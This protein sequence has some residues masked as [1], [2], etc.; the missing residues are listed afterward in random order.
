MHPHDYNLDQLMEIR[1]RGLRYLI[2]PRYKYHYVDNDYE[3]FSLDVFLQFATAGAL[4]VDVGAHFGIYSLLAARAGAN[5]VAFEPVPE[6]FEVL[7][8]NIALNQLAVTA[9]QAAAS[10]RDGLRSFNVAW[11]S[12]SASFSTHP[13]AETIARIEVVTRSLDSVLGESR[14]DVLKIDTEGHEIDVIRGAAEVLAANPKVK[15]LVE[16]G[17]DCLGSAGYEPE[18]LLGTLLSLGLRPYMIHEDD[19]ALT[20]IPDSL[21]WKDQM[22]G[23][24]YLNLICVADSPDDGLPEPLLQL[25]TSPQLSRSLSVGT[26]GRK[27]GR[28]PVGRLPRARGLPSLVHRGLVRAVAM[29]RWGRLAHTWDRAW[30]R[31]EA[32]WG[33]RPVRTMLHGTPAVLN[34]GHPYPVWARRWPSYNDP[35]VEAVLAT[36]VMM[37]RPVTVLDIGA[38]VGDTALLL[39]SSAASAIGRLIA[40]EADAEFLRYLRENLESVRF[41]TEVW[42]TYLSRDGGRL[43]G[44][45]RTQPGTGELAGPGQTA[46]RRL[47]DVWAEHGTPRVDVIKTDTDGY[48]GQVLAGARQLITASKPVIVFEWAPTCFDT[49]DNDAHEP[50][51]VLSELGYDR[52]IWFDK[53]GT[54]NHIEVG[55]SATTVEAQAALCRQ[56]KSLPS[57]HY[58][59]IALHAGHDLS[60][61]DVADLKRAF[62]HKVPVQPGLR[63]APSIH[64]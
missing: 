63:R 40:V 61:V 4:V 3:D 60:A 49:T 2:M 48:E 27:G 23:R 37:G 13:N 1:V 56:S 7:Q 54:F 12:D 42:P 24:S 25:T 19:R 6:N 8:R 34:F 43:P 21:E 10:D 15:V 26:D 57:W 41:T 52:F 14:V 51:A 17:P 55:Y 35:V 31:A 53:Y 5:V 64:R 18:E 11:A 16:F 32:R 59:I 62:A 33:G 38:N 36:H 20:R 45:V 39:D 29:R 58:D 46:S 30:A 9:H 22:R 50:F 44:V 47:D 28:K